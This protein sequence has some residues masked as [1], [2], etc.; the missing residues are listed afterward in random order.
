M[1]VD[2]KI[3][4]KALAS[5]L[6]SVIGFLVTSDQTAYVPGRFIGESVR[7]ISN[8]LEYTDNAEIPCYML[9]A[10][11]KK[12]FDSVSYTFLIAVL[13]KFGFGQ[14]FIRWIRILL[15]NHLSC[16]MNNGH[17]TGYIILHHGSRQGNPI[18]AFLF[19]LVLEI[20]LIQLRENKKWKD[21]NFLGMK[22]N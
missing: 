13:K 7:L 5:R 3:L 10:D 12:T 6:K 18:S 1:N 4:S 17:S 15:V 8:I 20:L 9:S 22:L 2:T 19:I 21:L 16:V 14:D 11:I